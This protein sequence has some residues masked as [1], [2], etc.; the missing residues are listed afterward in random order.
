[1]YLQKAKLDI[2]SDKEGLSIYCIFKT[3]S[4]HKKTKTK[5]I[6]YS[7]IREI[8]KDYMSE[9]TKEFTFHSL[10]SR[11]ASTAAINAISEKARN[12]YIN[13]SVVSVDSVSQMRL[14]CKR[15]LQV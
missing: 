9:V 13:D 11:G 10:R 7:R 15:H 5:G 6:L 1:M 2:S 12:G 14:D 4:R 3:K 8:F